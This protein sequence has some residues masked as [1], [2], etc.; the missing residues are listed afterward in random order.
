MADVAT[1]VSLGEL[2]AMPGWP[3]DKVIRKWIREEGLPVVQ[4]GSNGKPYLIDPVAATSWRD[5]RAA[6]KAEAERARASEVHKLSLDLLG[7]DAATN[8]GQLGL[9]PAERMALY[10]EEMTAIKLGELRGQFIRKAE[11]EVALTTLIEKVRRR[12]LGIP[13][14]LSKKTDL[15]RQL[16][17]QIND[18]VKSELD[19]LATEFEEMER[20]G[21]GTVAT[22]PVRNRKATRRAAGA[23]N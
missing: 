18:V 11:V 16:R 3:T 13:D 22:A 23:P 8:V 7:A 5:A 1:T 9:S 14:K 17:L 6:V 19:Q 12:F 20:P 10:E 2:A 4:A 15:S 21:A